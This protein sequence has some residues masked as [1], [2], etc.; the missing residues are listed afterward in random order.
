[1]GRG[2]KMFSSKKRCLW[3]GKTGV[4]RVL[5]SAGR[6]SNVAST[7]GWEAHT[8]TVHPP[9]LHSGGQKAFNFFS[10]LFLLFCLSS[11]LPTALHLVV[12]AIVCFEVIWETFRTKKSITNIIILHHYFAPAL[13]SLVILKVYLSFESVARN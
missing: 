6:N 5:Q 8:H 11:L 4:K 2:R 12:I 13:S 1:M 3:P 7:L 10:C 9:C